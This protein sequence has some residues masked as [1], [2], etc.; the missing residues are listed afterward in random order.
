MESLG[1]DTI[2]FH[3]AVYILNYEIVSSYNQIPPPN[4]GY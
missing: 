4:D 1:G 2:I 3:F